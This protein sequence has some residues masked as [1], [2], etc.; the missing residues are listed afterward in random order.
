MR[1]GDILKIINSMGLSWT[2]FRTSYELKKR[3][4]ILKRKF[5]TK[6]LCDEE[7]F[8]RINRNNLKDKISLANYIKE[9]KNRF[10]FTSKDLEQF[11]QFMD[12]KLSKNDKDKIIEIA[13]KA[14]EGKIYCFSHWFA[15]FGYPIN[16]HRNPIT[17]YEW[18]KTKHWAD[19]EELSETSGDVKYVWE[20]SR[21][22]QIFYFV[23][24]YTITQNEKYV[25][26]YWNQIEDWI[27]NNPYQ[28][29]I[30]WKCGQEITFRTFAWIFG[31]YA[32]LDS[33]YT[34]DE[35]IF[36]LI[37]N[38]YLNAL[39]IESNIDYAIKAVQNNHAISEAAGLFTVGVLF[40]FLKDSER[41]L[42]KGKKY[43]EQEGLKQIYE[44]GSYIQHSNNYHRLMLQ[45]YAWCYRLA[46]LN[47]IK[48]SNE[49]TNRIKLAIDFL[50]QMQDE[51][52][53]MVPN[54]GS[55]DGALI[56]PLSS[57][58]YLNYKPQLNTINYI[59][60]G[61][62]LYKPG[63]HEEDLLWFCGIEAVKS[64][65]IAKVIRITK[66]FDKGGYYVFRN[67]DS[68][69]MIRCTK[70]KHRP[71]QADMLH[72]D[73]WYKGINVLTDVGSYSYNPEKKFRGYF[74]ATKNHN[75][76]TINNQNQMKKGPRF[77]T[78][79][80]PE[81]FL[82]EFIF[83]KD[84]ILFSGYHIAY[85]NIHT[86]KIE[87]KDNC[88]II[89]DEIENKDGNKINIKLNWNIGTELKR[90]KDN[91]FKLIIND[92]E[93]LILEITS[94]TKG[95]SQ[96]YFGNEDKPAGWRSLYYGKKIPMNQLVY[97]VD[98]REE[99]EIV[100]TKICSR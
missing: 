28:L 55:N 78:I 41:F 6:V 18:P 61:K 10:L 54:Y 23:R 64:K 11:R 58:D 100:I 86:R 17:G 59:I 26:A 68:F 4:G 27:K 34:T 43:L 7:F 99:K 83:D 37:K 13:D 19:I 32:F 94:K 57:C 42:L 65:D 2:V 82:E 5:P 74:N 47:N 14:I 45:I 39:R 35:R 80:W 97:E 91:K 46:V 29:G 36:M 50:Y 30:N 76:V 31:L 90:I 3:T 56:F 38:I 40:P 84:K 95:K 24:A 98:S 63:K 8:N 70:F 62:K 22:P 49:L 77:L 88:Y 60:N 87:Y 33:N 89:T 93:N 81:G 66:R 75:T 85:K 52:T 20:A 69:G 1:I 9:N 21:F 96:I 79:D 71:G 67:K 51:K 44:D 92:K 72:F 73:L 53:G 48:F 16:W 25:Q 12:E 15:D